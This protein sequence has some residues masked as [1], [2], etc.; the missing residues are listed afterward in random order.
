MY[1]TIEAELKNG[2]VIPTGPDSL[3]ESGHVLV[4]ILPAPP[5]KTDWQEVRKSLGW[6][7]TDVDA[8]QWQREQR[9]EWESGT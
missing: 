5:A 9:A 7:H 6:L 1:K 3:P 8:A 4:V 2:R